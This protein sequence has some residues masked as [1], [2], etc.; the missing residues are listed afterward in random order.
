MY[1]NTLNGVIVVMIIIIILHIQPYN[2]VLV[3]NE[4]MKFFLKII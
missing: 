2:Y 1:S 3:Y 4:N